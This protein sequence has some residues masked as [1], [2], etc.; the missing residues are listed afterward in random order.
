MDQQQ[1]SKIVLALIAITISDSL[2]RSNVIDGKR[3]ILI[4]EINTNGNFMTAD[5]E[6]YIVQITGTGSEAVTS[7]DSIKVETFV[8]TEEIYTV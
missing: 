4:Q 1:L 5:P 3:D 7:S 8:T 2:S 6:E